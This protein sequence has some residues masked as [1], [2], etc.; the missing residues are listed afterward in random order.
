VHVR[1]Q[2]EGEG[3]AII[4][5]GNGDENSHEPEKASERS[6]F[7]GL[8]QVVVQSRRDG[9]G[10]LTL[11][12]TAPGLQA[13]QAVLDVQPAAAPPAVPVA[14]PV[15]LLTSWRTSPASATRPDPNVMV[16]DNDMNTWGWDEPPMRRGPESQAFRLYRTSFNVRA[17]NNDG[18]ARLVF[19]SVAGKAEVWVDGVKLGEKTSAAPAPFSVVLPQGATRRQLTLLI[20]AVPGQASGVWGRVALEPGAQ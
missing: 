7:N 3:G 5:V 15:T 4:G 14:Q 9:H 10:A 19:A 12:A 17:D 20:E 16:A 13:A 8:A 6:L 1:F 2:L 11:R 18:H